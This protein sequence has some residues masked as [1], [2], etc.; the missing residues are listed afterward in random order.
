MAESSSSTSSS[1][2]RLSSSSRSSSAEKAVASTSQPSSLRADQDAVAFIRALGFEQVDLLG[3]SSAAS[4]RR[5][6]ARRIAARS[7]IVLAGTGPAGGEGIDKVTLQPQPHDRRMGAGAGD[8]RPD[9]RA[10]GVTSGGNP[11]TTRALRPQSDLP[12]TLFTRVRGKVNSPKFATCE[13]GLYAKDSRAK[14]R[15]RRRRSR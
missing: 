14:R 8:H 9:A 6:C 4:S 10:A 15:R 2:R 11:R 13:A 12:L 7:K 5:D 3:F 1:S